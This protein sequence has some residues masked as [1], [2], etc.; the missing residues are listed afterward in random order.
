MYRNKSRWKIW[1]VIFGAIIVLISTFYS[2]YLAKQLAEEERKKVEL[3]LSATGELDS[4]NVYTTALLTE[5][6]DA[7]EP[8]YTFLLKIIQSNSTIPILIVSREGIVDDAI[9]Y[10]EADSLTLAGEYRRFVEDETEPIILDNQRLYFKESVLLTQLRY[11]PFIQL[12]LIAV[13]VLMGYAGFS[14]A[15]RAQENRVWVGMAKETAHQ[16]GTPISAILGWIEHLKMIREEDEE[17]AEVATELRNDVTRLELV[18]DRFSKIGSEPELKEIN[19]YDEIEKCRAYMQRRAPRKV[20]FHFPDPDDNLPINFKIN[21]PLFDWVIENLLRNALDAM[22]GK[23]EI[24]AEIYED[25]N[26]VFIDISDTGGGIPAGK[27][28]SVFEPGYTTK[29]RGWGLGL[30]LAKRIIEKYHTGK[31]FVKKSTENEGTTF[32][33]QMPKS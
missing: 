14:A 30:S 27:F 2:N 22:N 13:F 3:Y 15:R 24:R 26:Y 17:V 10:G 33:V 5:F 29:K 8:D 12:G 28:K 32:T 21:P 1:L 4:L 6:P 19:V 11:F 25:K 16:L 31:I 18:A 20:K 9:N 7:P 23:G